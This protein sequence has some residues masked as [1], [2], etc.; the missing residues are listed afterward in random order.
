MFLSSTD[1]VLS[2]LTGEPMPE[3]SPSPSTP[4]DLASA[5]PTQSSLGPTMDYRDAGSMPG[6]PIQ[7]TDVAPKLQGSPEQEPSFSRRRNRCEPGT[8]SNLDSWP[9]AWKRRSHVAD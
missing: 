7:S 9:A 1:E 8:A 4:P 3:K 6:S 5:A 2:L